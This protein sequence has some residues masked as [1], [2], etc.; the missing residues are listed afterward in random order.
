MVLFEHPIVLVALGVLIAA[1]I[2]SALA[3]EIIGRLIAYVNVLIHALMVVPLGILGF[4]IE[5]AVLFYMISVFA[6]TLTHTAV[7]VLRSIKI[8]KDRDNLS[9][10]EPDA[11]NEPMPQEAQEGGENDVA[12]FIVEDEDEIKEEEV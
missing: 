11:Q 2:A 5:D 12:D 1:H 7:Y 8:S 3:P 4:P 10:P 6:F 9:A